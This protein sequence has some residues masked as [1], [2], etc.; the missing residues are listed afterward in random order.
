MV[1]ILENVLIEQHL[2]TEVAFRLMVELVFLFELNDNK[3][4]AEVEDC[5]GY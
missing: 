5:N 2:F 3:M 4:A 1:I